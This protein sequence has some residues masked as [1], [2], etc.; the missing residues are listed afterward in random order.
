MKAMVTGAAGFI[1]SNLC[2]RLVKDG[3]DVIAVDDLSNGKLANLTSI[4]DRIKFRLIDI[5]DKL[6]DDLFNGVNTVFHLACSK[7]TVCAAN[8][9]RDFEVNAAGALNV[10]T[11][12]ADHGCKVVHASTGSVY[13]PSQ[14]HSEQ[15]SFNPVSFYGVSKL[16]GDRYLQA[17]QNYR[18]DFRFTAL[19]LF[20][21]YGPKQDASPIGGVVAIFINRILNNEPVQIFGD[22]YQVRSFT[23][24]DDVVDCF[25]AAAQNPRMDGE[26][27]N[28]AS[29]ARISLNH[30][31]ETL[32]EIM[33]I[34]PKV[35]YKETRLGDIRDFN[36]SNEKLRQE[37][38][39]NWSSFKDALT[40]TVEW[41]RGCA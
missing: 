23:H 20:H 22:G 8:P 14:F 41:Y 39:N 28:V 29:G 1:G 33:K 40:E 16:A 21:V 2:E 30:L 12:A 11:S 34:K 9:A 25:I 26:Y 17:L 4:S 27:Y 10:F 6:P 31:I 37:G 5:T 32:S 13:G 38:Y 15:T 19:R 35:E 24:V 18:K 3:H 36:V 7:C